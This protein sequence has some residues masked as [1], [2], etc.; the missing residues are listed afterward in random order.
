[1]WMNVF[2]VSHL[3]FPVSSKEVKNAKQARK[4]LKNHPKDKDYIYIKEFH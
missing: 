3:K 4:V 1:M 2:K